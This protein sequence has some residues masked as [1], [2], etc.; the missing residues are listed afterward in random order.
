[1]ATEAGQT[2]N[3]IVENMHAISHMTAEI[4]SAVNEQSTVVQDVDKNILRIRD[5]GQLVAAD[6]KENAEASEQVAQL[7]KVL[8]AEASIFKV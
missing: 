1:M 7:A 6:S 4:A 5:V 8:C 3:E 2:L